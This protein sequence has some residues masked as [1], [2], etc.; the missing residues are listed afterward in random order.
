MENRRR[1]EKLDEIISER[2]LCEWID[3]PVGKTG[4][5]K[6]ISYWINAGLRFIEKS[7]M[8]YFFEQDVIDLFWNGPQVESQ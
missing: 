1:P 8:R 6:Q 7:G 2:R 3:L 5:S 4:R